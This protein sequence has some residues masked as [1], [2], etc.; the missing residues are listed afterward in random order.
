MLH[1]SHVPLSEEHI[2]TMAE[3][4]LLEVCSHACEGELS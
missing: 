2:R 3:M 1:G 4:L